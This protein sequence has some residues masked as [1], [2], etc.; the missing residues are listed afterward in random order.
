MSAV[1]ED[2]AAAPGQQLGF[3]EVNG[4]RIAYATSGDGPPLLCDLGRIHDLGIF[5][6]HRP[7]RRFVEALAR[8]FTVVRFDR[9]GCGLSDR[10][11]ADFRLHADLSLIER[12]LDELG[13]D[14]TAALAAGGSARVMLAA[15]ALRPSRI[16]RLV[17]LGPRAADDSGEHRYYAALE[18]LLRT[19]VEV[20]VPL[21]AAGAASGGDEGSAEWL[22]GAYR[23]AATGEAIARCLAETVR[24]NVRPLL[25]R[26]RCPTLVLHRRD[27]VATDLAASREV[28][29]AI[30][31]AALLPLEG[32]AALAWDGDVQALL[33]PAMSF[34]RA[35]EEAAPGRATAELTAREHEV[36]H[37]V[38][39]GLTNAEIADRLA[40][41]RRTV[42]SH[43]ERV[44]SKLGLASRVELAAWS[45]RR[46]TS[47]DR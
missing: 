12:L 46:V 45:T 15:A 11:H 35:S 2:G 43:L 10:S 26:I 6:R 9:P 16:S 20:A 30:P 38:A 4:R 29:A 21:V 42:E 1:E 25:P 23:A 33:E 22:A 5:W 37:L 28:A 36:A 14:A 19:Q 17:V 27:N 44:R 40:I 39:L 7:Y 8:E 24:L 34:L 18:T 47:T 3:L 31:D 41:G 32:A 13:L